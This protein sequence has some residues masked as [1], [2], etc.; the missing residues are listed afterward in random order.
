MA[1][2][3]LVL[4]GGPGFPEGSPERRY[5]ITV[6]LTPGGHLDPQAWFA[7]PDPWP[8]RRSWPGSPSRDGDVQYDADTESW[9]VRLSP[10]PGD[11]ADT[12][13]HAQIRNA[14][15]LRPGEYVTIREP[16]GVEYSYR[17]VAVG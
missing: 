6:A 1:V 5:E 9:S 7:D 15:Q 10:D 17:V 16:D 4:A 11:S 3:T 12:P 14:A 13:L 8:A 2:V